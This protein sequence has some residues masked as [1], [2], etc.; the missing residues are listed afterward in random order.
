[1]RARL[2]FLVTVAL[3]VALATTALGWVAV[4]IAA[5][6]VAA[7]SATRGRPRAAGHIALAAALAWAALLAWD[8]AGPRFGALAAALGGIL[9]VPAAAIVFVTLALPAFLAWAAAALAEEFIAFARARSADVVT[10]PAPG[11]PARPTGSPA[12][13]SP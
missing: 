10:L 3:V 8:A 6:V 11:A 12:A 13:A 7:T 2:V 9:R 5:A 1:M 4:P